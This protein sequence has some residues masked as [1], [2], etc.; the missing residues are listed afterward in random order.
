MVLTSNYTIHKTSFWVGDEMYPASMADDV[1]WKQ[2][3][4]FQNNCTSKARELIWNWIDRYGL[5]HKYLN[6][7]VPKEEEE[8]FLWRQR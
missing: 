8:E 1:I 5:I 4:I 2:T 3:F 6:K 7:H